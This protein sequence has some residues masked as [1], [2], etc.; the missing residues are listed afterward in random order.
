MRR[1]WHPVAAALKLDERSI[2]AIRILGETL[3]Q[4]ARVQAV[5]DIWADEKPVEK[6]A[7]TQPTHR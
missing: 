2:K 4:R 1:C 7:G 5:F 3:E 6:A